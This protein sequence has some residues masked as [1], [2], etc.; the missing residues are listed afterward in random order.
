M[1]K[2]VLKERKEKKELVPVVIFQVSYLA[3]SRNSLVGTSS[4]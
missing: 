3:S 4:S 2:P 1:D